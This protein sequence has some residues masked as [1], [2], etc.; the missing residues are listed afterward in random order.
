M[1]IQTNSLISAGFHPVLEVEDDLVQ[2]R[3]TVKVYNVPLVNNYLA[4]FEYFPGQGPLKITDDV[5]IEVNKYREVFIWIP[6]IEYYDGPY[7]MDSND[8]MDLL[9]HAG[10]C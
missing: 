5:I 9:A 10:L 2:F 4:G 1:A 3:K 8:G 7:S 6:C